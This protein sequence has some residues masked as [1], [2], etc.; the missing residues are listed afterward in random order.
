MT[1]QKTGAEAEQVTLARSQCHNTESGYMQTHDYRCSK[2]TGYRVDNQ[3]SIP[4]WETNG[5]VDFNRVGDV[6]ES[7]AHIHLP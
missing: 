7:T 5:T 4:S 1:P 3:L 6:T 2:L